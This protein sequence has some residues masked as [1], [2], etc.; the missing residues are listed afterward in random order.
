MAL[1]YLERASRKKGVTIGALITLA[2]IYVRDK[3]I[4]E[5]ADSSR[6]RH[7]LIEK[8]PR[9]LLEEAAL[10]RLRGKVSEAELLFR[11]LLANPASGVPVRIRALY[12]L[13]SIL[14]GDGR[15]DEAM[16]PCWK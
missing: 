1:G 8:E 15:Y 3:R 4:D 13:A 5:A 14:D 12:D 7:K 9:V 11:N 6:G 10:L 2:D 16:A